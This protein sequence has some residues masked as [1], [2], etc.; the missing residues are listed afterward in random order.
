MEQAF[1]AK[2]SSEEIKRLLKAKYDE[3]A[4]AFFT[5]VGNGT[6]SNCSRYADAVAFSLYPSTGLEMIGFEIKVSRSDFLNEMKNPSKANDIMKFCDRWYLVCPKGMVLPDE[7]PKTWGLLEVGQEGRIYKKKIA[8]PLEPEPLNRKIISA[9]LRRATEGTVPK[10]VL[11]DEFD[12]VRKQ[13]IESAENAV[14]GKPNE[15]YFEENYNKL[16]E[17]VDQFEKAS[18][19]IIDSSWRDGNKVGEAVDIVF[20]NYIP[21]QLERLIRE[22]TI[23]KGNLEIVRDCQKN[24]FN[25]SHGT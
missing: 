19:I 16:K 4:F 21:G 10:S 24:I 20:N 14:K 23:I 8:P 7:L 5:E 17:K 22:V 11:R 15:S 3:P 25:N 1:I 13:A 12:R 9:L 6:G 18:G 2:L